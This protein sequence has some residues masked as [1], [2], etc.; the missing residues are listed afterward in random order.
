ML[1]RKKSWRP[2][3]Q[4]CGVAGRGVEE[5]ACGAP[6]RANHRSTRQRAARRR[7]CQWR[8]RRSRWRSMI[9]GSTPAPADAGAPKRRKGGGGWCCGALV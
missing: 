6:W 5:R 4:G 2:K 7:R 1:A 9:R 8:R 3:L